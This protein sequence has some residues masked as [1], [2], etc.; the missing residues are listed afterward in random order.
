M[1]KVTHQSKDFFSESKKS[2]SKIIHAT[3]NA[4]PNFQKSLVRL[5]QD[6]IDAWK[7][8]INSVISLEKEYSERV[9]FLPKVSDSTI[10]TIH[11]MTEM[12]IQAYLKQ[13][14]ILFD[15]VGTTEQAFATFNDST[16]S[17][18]S[19][20]K[21]IMELLMSKYGMQLKT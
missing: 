5:Q 19:I 21:G 13:N 2:N 3:K 14:E 8:V 4:S 20:N 7:T 18:T 12:S 10:Q 15:T 11:E 16:K 6:Y 1:S 17:F 9:G